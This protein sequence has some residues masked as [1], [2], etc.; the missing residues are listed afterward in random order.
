M[1]NRHKIRA[2]FD[3]LKRAAV[4]E[5]ALT[6]IIVRIRITSICYAISDSHKTYAELHAFECRASVERTPITS[7]AENLRQRIR[8]CQRLQGRTIRKRSAIDSCNPFRELNLGYAEILKGI[9]SD[10]RHRCAVDRCR[11]RQR[12]GQYRSVGLYDVRE[13]HFARTFS[14][15]PFKTVAVSKLCRPCRSRATDRRADCHNQL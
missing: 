13:R 11:N 12:S 6:C 5:C 1:T 2:E 14:I 15:G 9:Y 3:R 4:A 7:V 10:C 8:E